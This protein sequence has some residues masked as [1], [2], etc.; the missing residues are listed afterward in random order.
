MEKDVFSGAILAWVKS[1]KAPFFHRL[2]PVVHVP[3]GKYRHRR[4]AR[5][6]MLGQRHGP[7][8]GMLHPASG[9]GIELPASLRQRFLR[10]RRHTTLVILSGE[11]RVLKTKKAGQSARLIRLNLGP[12]TSSPLIYLILTKKAT[13]RPFML[14]WI[15]SMTSAG[16]TKSRTLNAV[17]SLPIS[18]NEAPK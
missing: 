5:H 12:S 2:L 9:A 15:F 10:E 14:S 6:G 16:V 17:I 7:V 13:H 3:A 11:H 1:A 8:Q 18:L 4:R